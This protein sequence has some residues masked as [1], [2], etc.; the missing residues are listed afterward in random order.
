LVL[1]TSAH[2]R[3]DIPPVTVCPRFYGTQVASNAIGRGP[4]ERD[5]PPCQAGKGFLATRRT[6][7]ARTASPPRGGASL[8]H[9]AYRPSTDPHPLSPP[10]P[11]GVLSAARLLEPGGGA[12]GGGPKCLPWGARMKPTP[13]CSLKWTTA[14]GSRRMRILLPCSRPRGSAEKEAIHVGQF[15]GCPGRSYSVDRHFGLDYALWERPGQSGAAE[16]SQPRQVRE[17]AAVRSLFWVPPASWPGRSVYALLARQARGGVQKH[18]PG[19][20][21]ARPAGRAVPIKSDS[22]SDYRGMPQRLVAQAG[23]GVERPLFDLTVEAVN[24]MRLRTSALW[25]FGQRMSSILV[26]LKTNSS[27]SSPHSVH[28]NS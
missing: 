24:E 28:S 4:R 27:N 14:G 16:T 22:R 18:R 9:L 8:V 3:R 12:R 26:R 10:L 20:N 19:P 25:Q 5:D 6:R 15:A 17:E 13:R 1:A 23:D 7:P 11:G 2:R 21:V